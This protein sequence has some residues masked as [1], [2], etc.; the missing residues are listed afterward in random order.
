MLISF[1]LCLFVRFYNILQGFINM[2][3]EMETSE[4]SLG[5]KYVSVFEIWIKVSLST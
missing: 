4:I 1:W 2:V 5:G 3:A